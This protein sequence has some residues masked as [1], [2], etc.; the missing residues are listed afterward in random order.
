MKKELLEA[1]D[2]ALKG[3]WDAAHL[4]V[5]EHED[6]ATAAWIHAVLHKLEGDQNNSRYWYNRADKINH[7]ADQPMAE[8]A[9]IRKVIALE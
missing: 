1:I 9:E 3:D 8:F 2:L 7:F 5:Q 6:D 4:I